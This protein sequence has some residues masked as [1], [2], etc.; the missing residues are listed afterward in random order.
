MG[1]DICCLIYNVNG[2]QTYTVWCYK[3][4][5]LQPDYNTVNAFV[6]TGPS[7]KRHSLERTQ[8][9]GSKYCECMWCS[10]SPKDTSL[11]RNFLA[12]GVSLLEGTTVL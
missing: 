11:I 2:P 7:V 8:V 9:F 3:P 4:N 10:L 5:T 1:P 12:E 6:Y